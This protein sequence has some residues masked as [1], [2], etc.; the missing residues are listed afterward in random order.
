VHG[1][2]VT[3]AL[4]CLNSLLQVNNKPTFIPEH[5]GVLQRQNHVFSLF[6]IVRA[7]RNLESRKVIYGK[8]AYIPPDPTHSLSS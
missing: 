3:V 2:Q 5:L 6:E 4:V 1:Q 7:M 8:S